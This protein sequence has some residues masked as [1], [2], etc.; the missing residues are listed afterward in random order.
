MFA[1]RS[2]GLHFDFVGQ[3]ADDA[4][5]GFQASEDVGA[6]H[7][8]E[9]AIARRVFQGGREGLEFLSYCDTA[10]IDKAAW[11]DLGMLPGCAM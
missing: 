7:V 1:Q 4:G 11:S 6:D 3:V 9:T 8:P 2:K 5:V 10:S